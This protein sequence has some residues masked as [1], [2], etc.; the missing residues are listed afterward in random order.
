MTTTGEDPGSLTPS[1]LDAPLVDP[2]GLLID[3]TSVF[4]L[5]LDLGPVQLDL[6]GRAVFFLVVSAAALGIAA[7]PVFLSRRPELRAKW[8]TWALI[9]PVLGLP[10]WLGPGAT[11]VFAAA[12]ATVCVIEFARMTG[13]RRTERTI[14]V[15]L[16]WLYP[17]CAWLR[18]ELLSLVPLVALL[19]AVPA[20]LDGD[21]NDGLR[22]AAFTSFGSIW[23]CWSLANLVLVGNQAYLICFAAAAT[24]IAAWCGGKGLR[25]L[26]WA[27]TPLSP[28]SPNKTLG[29]L[30]G[31]IVGAALILLVLGGLTPGMLIAVALGAVGGDLLESM[32]KR[33]AGVKDAGNWLPGFGGMLD[34]ADSLLLV[35]PLAAVLA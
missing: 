28:L 31:G 3:R 5:H 2:L 20:L 8:S 13:L 7:V 19:C 10:I 16:A 23:L 25:R 4:S 29:G 6:A 32:V 1:L 35:L 12:V 17:L 33:Q 9:L 21:V 26:A 18:P 24:D 30:V 22:R 14:L 34:R 15:A 11:A 27:R